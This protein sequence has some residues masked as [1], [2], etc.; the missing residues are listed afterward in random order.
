MKPWEK[1]PQGWH[2]GK[3]DVFPWMNYFWGFCCGLTR[4][5]KSVSEPSGAAGSLRQELI[6]MAVNRKIEPFPYR[7][8]GGLPRN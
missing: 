1:A 7:N 6:K 4:S 2:E 8:R 3:H 5:L